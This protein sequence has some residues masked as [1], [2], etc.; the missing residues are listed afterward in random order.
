MSTW[1]SRPSIPVNR[2]VS[3]IASF[4]GND[5]LSS[6]RTSWPMWATIVAGV[7]RTFL[8]SPRGLS[9]RTIG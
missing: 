6:G 3:P 8:S 4:S 7:A 2:V 5:G 9:G 1:P